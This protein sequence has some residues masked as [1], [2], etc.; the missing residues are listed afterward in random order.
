MQPTHG[1]LLAGFR[2]RYTDDESRKYLETHARRYEVLLA[3]VERLAAG[4]AGF[5]ILDVGP[6]YQTE[7]MRA[8]L[9]GAVV[10]TL[11]WADP[12]FPPRP[13]ERHVE[14]DLNDVRAPDLA[15]PV[16]A[17]DLVVLA[18][19]VEHLHTAPV[20]VLRF[21]ARA[22]RSGGHLILQTPNACALFKRLA[23]LRGRNPFEPIRENPAHPGHFREYTLDE[24]LALGP[25]AGLAAVEWATANYFDHGSRKHRAFVALEPVVPARLRDGITVLYRREGS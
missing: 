19:V 25:P 1:E 15:A 13:G 14:L 17:A 23:L 10:D 16:D 4:R 21:L 6:A 22:L 9:G 7:A 12:R 8:R 18:E 5:R 20:L 11:G 2:A 24:L 3:L